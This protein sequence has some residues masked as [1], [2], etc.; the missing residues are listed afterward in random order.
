MKKIAIVA[1][2]S[3]FAA[4]TA[5]AEN[6]GKFYGALDVGKASFNDAGGF[7]NPGVF[8]ISGGYHVTPAV[9]VE[10]SYSKNGDSTLVDST[11][12]SATLSALSLQFAVVGNLPISPEFDFI[13]KIGVA[14]NRAD[15]STNIGFSSSPSSTNLM[16]GLG[17]QY[18]LNSQ[19]GIRALYDN[20]GKVGGS[21]GTAKGSDI[22]LGVAYNL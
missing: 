11:G 10:V 6:S 19:V 21:N 13:G 4:A 15:I 20:F 3:V 8:R 17:A 16:F 22:T 7:P 2:L 18:N 14:S 12:A 9:A 1:L 5:L